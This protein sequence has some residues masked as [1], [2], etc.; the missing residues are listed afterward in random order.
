[1]SFRFLKDKSVFCLENNNLHLD[2]GRET[3]KTSAINKARDDS[4]QLWGV[5][6]GQHPGYIL[7]VEL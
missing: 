7:K 5:K 3:N 2:G 6:S 4:V 1:M